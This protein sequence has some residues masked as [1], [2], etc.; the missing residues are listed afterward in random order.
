MP[1]APGTF[2]T[3][4]GL[5]KDVPTAAAQQA[6]QDVGIAARRRGREQVHRRGLGNGLVCALRSRCGGVRAHPSAIAAMRRMDFLPL[7]LSK[8]GFAPDVLRQLDNQPQ[9]CFLHLAA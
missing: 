1:P 5:P 4:K 6:R 8:L 3:T 7:P 9:L 2:S